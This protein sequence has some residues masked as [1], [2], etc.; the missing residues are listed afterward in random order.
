[1]MAATVVGTKL[2]F[3]I[4]IAYFVAIF[5]FGALFAR[6]TRSTRDFFFGGQRYAWWLIAFSAV[7][8][9]V[10]SYSFIKYSAVGFQFGMSSTMS[11]LND[12]IVMGLFLLTWLP[13]IYYSRVASVPEY[14]ERRFDAR[15]RAM[16]TIIILIYMIGYIGINLYT[17]GVALNAMLGTDIFWSA[18]AVAV[19]CSVYVTAGG[20]TSV[21]MTDLLQGVLLIVAGLT[22]FALGLLYLG[23]FDTFWRLLPEAWRLPM[24]SFNEPHSFHFAGVFW[25]DGIANNIAFYFMNQGMLLRFLSV[26]SVRDARKAFLFIL[27][28]L[29]PLAALAVAN[30]GWL[31]K[32]FVEAGLLPADTAPKKIFVAV[33]AL[34]C[35]PGM[36]G[37]IMA[38]LIAALMSTIDTLINA[39]SVVGVNDIYRPYIMRDRSDR[40][41]LRAARV[42]SLAAGGIGIALVP[43]F[44]QFKSIYVAHGA[45]IASVTPPMVVAILLGVFWKR[46][47]PTAA[48]ATLLGG[49][50]AVGISIWHP[51]LIAPLAH[52]VDPAGGFKYMRALYGIAAAGLIGIVV[53]FITKPKPL[54]E[55]QGLVLGTIRAGRERFKGGVVNEHPGTPFVGQLSSIPGE[56]ILRLHPNAMSQMNASPGDLLYLA[57]ARRWLGGLRSIHATA[58]EPHDRAEAIILVSGDL[59][60]EGELLVGRKHRAEVI[61]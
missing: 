55:I 17:M 60:A 25:Q 11:Y 29:M 23:G 28:I 30:A 49:A 19:V 10:G 36:F 45:F 3:A 6:F 34:L 61:L 56:R 54:A 15:S 59:I 43:V 47:T 46:F 18:V 39:V 38:A 41:Y 44:A 52:G 33:A 53:T 48:F 4:I 31:G 1:M 50:L 14:F 24:A 27:I 20:Q 40:H 51:E 16:A 2:D 26:R 9:T 22:L 42:I 12:W 21:I 37:L 5:G 32:A 58:G 57:D 35:R 8:T 7:A 13:I